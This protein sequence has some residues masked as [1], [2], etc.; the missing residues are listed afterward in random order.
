MSGG[1]VQRGQLLKT[2]LDQRA[3]VN[4]I[5]EF[6]AWAYS[7]GRSPQWIEG[8]FWDFFLAAAPDEM[9]KV[10][11]SPSKSV[12]RATAR[13]DWSAMPAIARDGF[14]S[15]IE[16]REPE[17]GLDLE[18]IPRVMSTWTGPDG[19][20]YHHYGSQAITA[21][22][23]TDILRAALDEALCDLRGLAVEALGQCEECKHYFVRL[24]AA[25]RRFCSPKCTWK[26][27]QTRR[28]HRPA[29]FK[30]RAVRKVK[31]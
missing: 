12:R 29:S 23:E 30:R 25:R 5:R 28:R 15:A 17:L 1:A 22:N 10:F 9:R 19:R 11:K 21:L 18:R 31:R 26:A 27:F 16:K 13:W 7:D 4:Y 24:R 3:R 6:L 20:R 8:T 2:P 14:E